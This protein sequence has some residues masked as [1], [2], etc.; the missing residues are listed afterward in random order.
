MIEINK[1]HKGDCLEVMK[2]ID[3]KSVD[4]ILCD[5][6][7]GV[8]ARNKWDIIIPFDKLWEQYRRIIKDNGIICLTATNPFASDLIQSARDIFRYDLIWEKSQGTG[9]L[10]ANR[11]PLRSHELVLVFY[12]KLILFLSGLLNQTSASKN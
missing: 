3:D 2:Q 4:L 12:K 9:F 11:M 8:T 7:Y 1:I 6:P 5:L 10:N